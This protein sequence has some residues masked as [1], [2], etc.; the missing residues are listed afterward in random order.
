MST[1][2]KQQARRAELQFILTDVWNSERQGYSF[3]VWLDKQTQD[4]SRVGWQDE[5]K[6][7][8]ALYEEL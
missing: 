6:E 5:A 2:A 7:L 8:I 4:I 3:Y 1:K